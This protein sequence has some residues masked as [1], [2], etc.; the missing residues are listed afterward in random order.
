MRKWL[1]A[2]VL[3]LTC[4]LHVNAEGFSKKPSNTPQLIQT[5]KEKAWC[6]V[7]G[8]SLKGFYKTSHTAHTH[9]GVPT[10]YCS[11]R[12]LVLDE[13]ERHTDL[14]KAMVVDV[15]TDKLISVKDAYY[16]VGS[17]V[18]GT[19][20]KVSKLAFATEKDANAFAAKNGGE[21]KRFN[22][23]YALAKT[24][25]KQDIA[26]SNAKKQ[27]MMYPMGQ[28]LLKAK[29][30]A[31]KLDPYTFPR[32]NA[33]K[34]AVKDNC[35]ALEEKQ[36]QAVALY[37]WEVKRFEGSLSS[38]QISVTK[39]E[40][41]PV[42]GM[43]VYK[44]PKWAS[45]LYFQKEGKE[46]SH[47]FDGVKDMAKY[48]QTPATYHAHKDFNVDR[49][50]VTDYYTQLAI[51]GRSAYYVVGS[52]VL[53]PMGHELIPFKNETDAK[54]FMKDHKGSAIVTFDKITPQMICKLDGKP[55]K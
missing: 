16:V 24:S 9:E 53:G 4:S 32:I 43:F 26:M 44:Y 17:N 46:H 52:D 5:G 33:L 47:A 25:L 23:V 15:T 18:M 30:N 34:A 55:C 22:E 10:Q 40:K 3:I 8:M 41:C 29:C 45:R 19:M 27:K 35:Q 21:I 13:Q 11:L 38:K 12:C 36:M 28:K 48:V 31:A 2:G 54:T 51:D 1:L 50:V 20:S 6:P 14:A 37:L 7:C 42:C 39:E 49:I